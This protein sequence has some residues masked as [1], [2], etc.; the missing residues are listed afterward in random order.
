M[1]ALPDIDGQPALS[2]PEIEFTVP[3]I[4]KLLNNLNPAKASGPDLVPA[5]ILKSNLQGESACSV[6]DISAL[7]K[8]W[9]SSTGLAA[10]QHH[11]SLQKG[12]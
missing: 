9:P 7:L 12:R 8:Y 5:R 4:E 11:S 1:S 3:G 6:C 2:V 10:C